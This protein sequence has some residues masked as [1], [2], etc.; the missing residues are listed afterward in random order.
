MK[1]LTTILFIALA[2][3]L[4]TNCS[5]NSNGSHSKGVYLTPLNEI[6]FPIST[7]EKGTPLKLIAFTGG[8]Q[9]D[10]KHT[11]YYQFIAINQSSGDTV[12]VLVP[13]I[14][15]GEENIY[16]TPLQY[17]HDKGIEAATFEPKD[18]SFDMKINAFA[19][20]DTPPAHGDEIDK[21]QQKSSAAELVV[22]V[23]KIPLFENPRYKTVIG[24]LHFDE[25]PW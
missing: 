22:M 7:L 1:R 25:R 23:K 12:R 2:I 11:Y 24:A 9:S 21:M 4:L 14:S 13:L 15:V 18:S 6:P 10:K 3:S 8:N 17:D 19:F 20:G 5:S 16:T